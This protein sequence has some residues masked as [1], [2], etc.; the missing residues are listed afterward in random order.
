MLASPSRTRKE[1][2]RA[3]VDRNDAGIPLYEKF[4]FEMEGTHRRYALREGAY[5]DA[6]SMARIKPSTVRPSAA[7]KSFIGDVSGPTFHFCDFC[8]VTGATGGLL[9]LRPTAPG[10]VGCSGT[11]S[12]V[13]RREERPARPLFFGF[14]RRWPW[15]WS[16]CYRP[17]LAAE[18]FVVNRTT[19]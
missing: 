6:Y 4:G 3:F 5:A 9:P 8:I 17:G 14:W 11:F 2:L 13:R 7:E 1:R 16:C 12:Q 10:R 19:D 18:T 15:E